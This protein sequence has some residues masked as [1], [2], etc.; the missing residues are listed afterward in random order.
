MQYSFLASYLLIIFALWYSRREQFGLEKMILTNSILAMVQLGLLGYALVYLFQMKH[1]ALLFFVL[2]GMVTFGA[3]TAKKRAPL[4]EHSFKIAFFSLGASSGIV[5]LS[6]MAFGVIHMVPNEMIPIGGMIIGNALN[7]YSQ[8][9]ERFRAE[10]KNTI[11]TIEGMVALGAPMKEAL[12][13]ASK[14]SVKASM[15]PTLNMLQTVGII[16]IPGITTGM[17]LAGADPLSAISYQLAVMYMMVAVA[18]LSAVFSVM[19]S[20][21]IIIGSAFTSKQ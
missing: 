3:Y 13:L 9:I 5:F 7:V 11:E 20:Y 21:R 12:R 16:H 4:G 18:L 17:L 6:M 8:S 19:F 10:V 14:A 15:I 1:P 2:L